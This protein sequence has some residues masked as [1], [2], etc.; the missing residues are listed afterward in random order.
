MHCVLPFCVS[1]S[2]STLREESCVILV[3]CP[4]F[5]GSNKASSDLIFIGKDIDRMK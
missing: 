1:Q 2:I 5:Q 3:C 4:M